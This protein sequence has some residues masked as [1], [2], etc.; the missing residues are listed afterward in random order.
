MNLVDSDDDN[1]SVDLAFANLDM[2]DVDFDNEGGE[3]KTEVTITLLD[4]QAMEMQQQFLLE[5]HKQLLAILSSSRCSR[6]D[7]GDNGEAEE[8]SRLFHLVNLVVNGNCP[9]DSVFAYVS[10]HEGFPI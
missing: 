8:T 10:N 4:Q 6:D 3:N 5:D 9:T 2:T 1:S 7:E